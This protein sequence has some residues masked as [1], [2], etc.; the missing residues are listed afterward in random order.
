ML[1]Q[2]AILVAGS[3]IALAIVG[4]ELGSFGP[5]FFEHDWYEAVALPLGVLAACC[6]I[7][8]Y[9]SYI[10]I[11][12]GAY[13]FLVLLLVRFVELALDIYFFAKP[14]SMLFTPA[15][16]LLLETL[17]E[18]GFIGVASSGFAL[19]LTSLGVR[20]LRVNRLVAGYLISAVAVAFALSFEPPFFRSVSG[21]WFFVIEAIVWL[22]L[23]AAAA[24]IFVSLQ[25]PLRRAN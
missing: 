10:P 1:K 25:L 4:I 8:A 6:V 3:V 16:T 15:N 7:Y 2:E 14:N 19:V 23:G 9:H 20:H 18:M 11:K 22:V 17:L 13:F 5:L 21:S 12:A 24:G